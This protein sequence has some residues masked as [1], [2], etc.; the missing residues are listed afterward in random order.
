[1][2]GSASVSNFPL[3][4]TITVGKL[5]PKESAVRIQFCSVQ[6]CPALCNAMD[7]ST[8]GFLVHHQ[9]PELAQTHVHQ[10]G[11]AISASVFPFP[12][13]FSL[14]QDQGLFQW[15]SSPH[16][17]DN[18]L[19][20]QLQHQSSQWVFRD[21]SFRM[22][23]LDLLKVQG[24]LKS[25]LQHHSSKASVLRRSALSFLFFFFFW[26]FKKLSYLSRRL[27][28]WQ[29]MAQLSHPYMRLT[30]RQQALESTETIFVGTCSSLLGAGLQPSWKL[31]TSPLLSLLETPGLSL[32]LF[33]SWGNWGIEKFSNT[34][35]N[36]KATLEKLGLETRS[37]FL[38]QLLIDL[39]SVYWTTAMCHPW[40]EIMEFQQWSADKKR[41]LWC[42]S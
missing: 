17:V 14:S 7:C 42:S 35:E 27:I 11:N 20:F 36:E 30:W 22:N 32:V 38:I 13:A 33:H 40:L 31:H 41:L 8:P 24:T 6:L 28:T 23:W 3:W 21:D 10:C 9:L 39:I 25:L 16:Q 15:V 1:M 29:I 18:V 37:D 26:I 19:E 4:I 2:Q 12:P 34:S 5:W